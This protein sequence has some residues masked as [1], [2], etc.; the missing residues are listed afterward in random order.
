MVSIKCEGNDTQPKNLHLKKAILKIW[1]IY[2]I[3]IDLFVVFL[4]L[5]NPYHRS[6][7]FKIITALLHYRT[8]DKQP[9]QFLLSFCGEHVPSN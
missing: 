8:Y 1:E 4:K 5:Q 2:Q 3:F 7:A 6:A 9:V